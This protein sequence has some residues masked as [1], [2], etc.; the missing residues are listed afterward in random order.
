MSGRVRL[1]DLRTG[2]MGSDCRTGFGKDLKFSEG[3]KGVSRC[4]RR[5]ALSAIPIGSK[6][7]W[8]KLTGTIINNT[9]PGLSTHFVLFC[10][11]L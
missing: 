10:F 9:V 5:I 7:V 11:V 8:N 1:N 4:G 3:V 6:E 2:T